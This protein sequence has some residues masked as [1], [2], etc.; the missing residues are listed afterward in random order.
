MGKSMQDEWGNARRIGMCWRSA[1]TRQKQRDRVN[2]RPG[3]GSA[4]GEARLA[5]LQRQI[6]DPVKVVGVCY[7]V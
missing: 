3:C 5:G 2:P 1:T 6:K 4:G 7:L